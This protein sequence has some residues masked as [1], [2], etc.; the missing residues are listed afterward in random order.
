MSPTKQSIFSPRAQNVKFDFDG[1]K[2]NSKMSDTSQGS[3][4]T[5]MLTLNNLPA[6]SGSESDCD[7]NVSPYMN[8]CPRIEEEADEVFDTK[9]YNFKNA[10]NKQNG[11]VT[12]PTYI[13]F[14]VD[15]EKKPQNIPNNY[16]N[17]NVPNGL[18]K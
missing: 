3:E 7:G 14:D 15:L 11:A 5:P 6:R 16:I 1:R 9:Q 10:Q 18:V 2:L 17:V 12:N 8:M 13:T 4:L